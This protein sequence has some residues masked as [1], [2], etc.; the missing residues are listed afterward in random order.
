M[1]V[2]TWKLSL[3][4]KYKISYNIANITL[5]LSKS[6]F[7]YNVNSSFDFLNANF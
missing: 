1:V 4:L 5:T 6:K 7:F 2:A 3:S